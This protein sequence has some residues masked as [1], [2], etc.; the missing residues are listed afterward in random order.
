MQRRISSHPP[1][2]PRRP[3][4]HNE[5]EDSTSQRSRQLLA[6]GPLPPRPP[7]SVDGGAAG[8]N[9]RPG[10]FVTGRQKA[11]PSG[12]PRR[13]HPFPSGRRSPSAP[14][15]TQGWESKGSKG[16]ALSTTVGRSDGRRG[17]GVLDSQRCLEL[18]L[19]V[20]RLLGSS[21]APGQ[22][23]DRPVGLR[24]TES[25]PPS[26]EGLPDGRWIEPPPSTDPGPDRDHRPQLDVDPHSEADLM[27]ENRPDPDRR[28]DEGPPRHV[29]CPE[30][31]NARNEREHHR[32]RDHSGAGVSPPANRTNLP[33]STLDAYA[34]G[35]SDRRDGQLERWPLEQ[36]PALRAWCDAEHVV[37]RIDVRAAGRAREHPESVIRTGARSP[38]PAR[39]CPPRG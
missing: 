6:Q 9:T 39:P 2:A 33:V 37:P 12:N 8:R 23:H 15:C 7:G 27:P 32:R 36:A 14:W 3:V 18:V 25:V 34:F 13:Q 1:S 20:P 16:A 17:A 5:R 26:H 29:R 19:D 4:R 21:E 28:Q 31:R 30:V 10:A 24:G 22:G 38:L 11:S 35:W